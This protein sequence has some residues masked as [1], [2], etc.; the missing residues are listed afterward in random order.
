LNPKNFAATY[1]LGAYYFNQ[2]GALNEAMNKLGYSKPDQEKFDELKEKQTKIF[3][4]AKPYFLLAK[5][6][7]PDDEATLKVL[8]QI[9]TYL[10]Q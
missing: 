2:A 6:L 1:N 4:T 7:Q 9:D 8:K 5:E 10:A 3:K